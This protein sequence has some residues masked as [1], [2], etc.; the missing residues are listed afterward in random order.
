MTIC[1]LELARYVSI[2]S[3]GLWYE[4]IFTPQCLW[5]PGWHHLCGL[6][7]NPPWMQSWN[8]V[9]QSWLIRKMKP[10]IGHQLRN[11]PINIWN[12]KGEHNIERNNKRDKEHNNLNLHR[13]LHPI[14]INDG[15]P[16]YCWSCTFSLFTICHLALISLWQRRLKRHE[17]RKKKLWLNDVQHRCIGSCAIRLSG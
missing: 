13:F 4:M 11:R 15:Q 10:P 5:A 7:R 6:Y 9:H 12:G 3:L 1:T 14:L 8:H 2:I 16:V 17:K